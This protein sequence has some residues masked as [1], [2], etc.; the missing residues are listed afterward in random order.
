MSED[1]RIL[2]L[3]LECTLRDRLAWSRIAP[4]TYEA[5]SGS[6]VMAEVQFLYPLV[7]DGDV[8]GADIAQ[9]TMGRTMLLYYSGT[10]GMYRIREIL[11]AGLPEWRDHR[12][13]ASERMSEIVSRLED[14]LRR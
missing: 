2:D 14:L 10:R 7:A 3:L 12:K 8:L 11:Q 6:E 13:L 9:V 4:D 1:L 5:R